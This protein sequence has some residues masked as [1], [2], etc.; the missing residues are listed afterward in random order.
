M[1]QIPLQCA[2]GGEGV[3][4]YVIDT[5][6]NIKHVDFGVVPTWGKTIPAT[7]LMRLQWAR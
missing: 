3:D 6:T 1:E 5:G 7:M 2:D 4:V